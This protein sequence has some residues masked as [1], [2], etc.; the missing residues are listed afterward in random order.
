MKTKC[1]ALRMLWTVALAME[2]S[3]SKSSAQLLVERSSW[4]VQELLL[5]PGIF[6]AF[7]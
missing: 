4:H 6:A 5:M 2:A 1:R 7:A 3:V